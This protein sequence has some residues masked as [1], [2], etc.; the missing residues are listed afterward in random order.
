M[1]PAL[2]TWSKNT[3][4]RLRPAHGF[5]RLYTAQSGFLLLLRLWLQVWPALPATQRL[6]SRTDLARLSCF[7]L[8]YRLYII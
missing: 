5:G 6:C 7:P 8:V 2:A 4:S 3:K 1:A